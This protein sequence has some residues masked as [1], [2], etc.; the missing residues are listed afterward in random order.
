MMTAVGG[1]VNGN[2]GNDI[3]KWLLF[4]L[5]GGLGLVGGIGLG[6]TLGKK[7]G[8]VE[9]KEAFKKARHKA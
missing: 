2:N 7:N 8:A 3:N 4:G 9:A 6:Y 5:G 1:N